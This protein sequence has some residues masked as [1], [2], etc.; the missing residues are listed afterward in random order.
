MYGAGLGHFLSTIAIHGLPFNIV[1]AADTT[2]RGRTFLR[3]LAKCPRV[4]GGLEDMIKAVTS[5]VEFSLA[6]YIVHSPVRGIIPSKYDYF[7]QF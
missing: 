3:H 2:V 4:V 7:W 5:T 1:L 6:G